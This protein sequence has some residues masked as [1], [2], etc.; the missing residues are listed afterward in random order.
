MVVPLLNRHIGA[1][2]LLPWLSLV[3]FIAVAP[4]TVLVFLTSE[5]AITNYRV[6]FKVG[7]IRRRTIEILLAKVETISIDQ[8]VLGRLLGY[9]T[10]VVVGTGGSKETFPR[11]RAPLEFRHHVYEQLSHPAT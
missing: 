7:F 4:K 9:G 8:P 11:I 3:C 6:V 5:F 1:V 2:P 10:V